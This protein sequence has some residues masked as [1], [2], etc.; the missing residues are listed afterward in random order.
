MTLALYMDHHV[1]G[2]ISNGLRLRGVDVLTAFEDGAHQFTDPQLLDRATSLGRVFF[3]QDED[4]LVEAARRQK[5]GEHFAGLLY[6]H[7]SL[8]VGRC[9]QDLEVIALASEPSELFDRVIYLPI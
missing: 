5:S 3:S 8:P 1:H 9:I 4:L 7:Q 2:G 6:A